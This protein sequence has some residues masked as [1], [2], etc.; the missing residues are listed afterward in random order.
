MFPI[1]SSTTIQSGTSPSAAQSAAPAK[2]AVIPN[3]LQRVRDLLFPSMFVHL[4][5]KPQNPNRPI[6]SLGKTPNPIYLQ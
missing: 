6:S 2:S 5:N 3:P 1:C 4:A